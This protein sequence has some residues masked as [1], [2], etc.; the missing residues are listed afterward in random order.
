MS[1]SRELHRYCLD[2]REFEDVAAAV[3]YRFVLHNVEFMRGSKEG[4]GHLLALTRTN[5]L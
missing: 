4:E 2:E 5:G 3:Q 1:S